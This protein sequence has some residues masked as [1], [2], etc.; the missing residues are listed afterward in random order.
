VVAR[1]LGGDPYRGFFSRLSV[2][3]L[4]GDDAV[5]RLSPDELVLATGLLV[6]GLGREIT[7]DLRGKGWTGMYVLSLPCPVPR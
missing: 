5:G 1:S 7:G 3:S 2:S 6:S 4:I